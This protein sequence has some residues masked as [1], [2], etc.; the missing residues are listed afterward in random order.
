MYVGDWALGIG[1]WM[2]ACSCSNNISDERQ[3]IYIISNHS[4]YFALPATG[5]WDSL[6]LSHTDN[7]TNMDTGA[8]LSLI[9]K[10]I[11]KKKEKRKT[12]LQMQ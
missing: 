9:A 12:A 7:D 4:V 1:H 11:R 2:Q 5:N 6:S 10:K 3:A 8:T